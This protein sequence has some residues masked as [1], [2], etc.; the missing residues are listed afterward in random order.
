GRGLG[1]LPVAVLTLAGVVER[2]A[3]VF[4]LLLCN[5]R[6]V[7]C[8]WVNSARLTLFTGAVVWELVMLSFILK[9]S[10]LYPDMSGEAI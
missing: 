5:D 8:P 6:A 3:T 1:L 10:V 7:L 4:L 2:S 9:A